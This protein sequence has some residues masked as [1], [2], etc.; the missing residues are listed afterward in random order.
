MAL[1]TLIGLPAAIFCLVRGAV[2]LRQRRYAW[3]FLGVA[4]GL[5]LLLT[6]LPTH[7]VKYD[8]PMQN[9]R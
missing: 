7:A 6:P 9:R 3:G 8:L 1:W 5:L 2:D 4:S